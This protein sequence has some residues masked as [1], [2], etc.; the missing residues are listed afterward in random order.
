LV[1]DTLYLDGFRIG[2]A[3]NSAALQLDFCFRADDLWQ[4][5]LDFVSA[6]VTDPCDLSSFRR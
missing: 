3:R 6:L 1:N 4:N 5:C 2:Q